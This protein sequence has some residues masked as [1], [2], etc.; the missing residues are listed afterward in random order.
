MNLPGTVFF[1]R[2]LREGTRQIRT[3]VIR[4]ALLLGVLSMLASA[5]ATRSM[6]GAPGLQL[7]G[8][9][10]M[11]NLVLICLAAPGY[12]AS[13]ITEEKEAGTLGLLKMAGLNPVSILLGKST[14]Q[15]LG[16]V[17]LLLVQVPFTVL[18]VTLG[19][20]SL[21]QVFAGYLT[22][23]AFLL[24]MGNMALLFSV[25]CRH[26]GRAAGMCILA[27]MAFFFGPPLGKALLAGLVRSGAVLRGGGTDQMV[28]G[29]FDLVTNASPFAWMETVLATGFSGPLVGFQ[30]WSNLALA[31]GCF[32]L[33]WK[34]FDPFTREQVTAAPPR[35]LLTR[36]IGR[37]SALGA[38][39]AWTNALA[40]KDF[41]FMSGG[42]VAFLARLVL[43]GLIPAVVVTCIASSGGNPSK[44][45]IGAT[46]LWVSLLLLFLE[47]VAL[48]GRIFGE[49]R[50]WQTLSA[51]VVLPYTPRQIVWRKALGCGLG[52]LPYAVWILV[53]AVLA[54]HGFAKFLGEAVKEVGFWFFLAYFLLFFHLIAYISL[55]I[56]RGAVLLAFAICFFGGQFLAIPISL[57]AF[58][59]G[60]NVV[61]T[62]LL[63]ATIVLILL[64]QRGIA[65]RLMRAGEL[66]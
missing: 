12:F 37:L 46:F 11:L 56:K 26:S 42:K 25:M 14:S 8:G 58:A 33:A 15:V 29:L 28:R 19:G 65:R 51:I 31:G 53:G 52:L 49:E 62:V 2:S 60:V 61:F 57:M 24:F 45:D 18:A 54:G 22:M 64:L 44:E 6:F 7:F 41:N 39:R 40:W 34:T 17:M 47:L 36:R 1:G 5:Q 30:F 59:G 20:V 63:V 9:I 48:S 10:A 16:A 13:V 55:I 50:K 66:E 21:P 43:V 27:L 3:Y 32:L 23:L 35:G 38:G 4:G